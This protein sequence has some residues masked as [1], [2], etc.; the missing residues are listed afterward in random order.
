LPAEA[1]TSPAVYERE[2]ARIFGR[3]WLCA[4]R[5]DQIPERGD[6]FCLDLLDEKLVVV[7]GDD[8]EIRAL[9][10][11]CRHRAAE[12]A[13]GTGNART[14]VCPYHSWAYDLEGSLV[15]VPM[16]GRIG[17]FDREACRLPA[18]RC[19]L[20]EGWIFVNFDPV[21]AALAPQ[22]EPLSKLLAPYSMAS[23]AVAETTSYPS[24]FNWK[25]LVDN[26]MEAYHHIATHRDTLQPL[27]PAALSWVPDNDGPWSALVM[28]FRPEAGAGAP[29][30]PGA[31][32]PEGEPKPLVAAVVYPFHLF[33]PSGDSMAWYQILPERHD[34]FTLRIHTCFQRGGVGDEADAA[35]RAGMHEFTNAVHAQD[36]GACESVWTGLASP[37]FQSGRLSTL[38]KAIWQFNQW[39]AERMEVD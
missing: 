6:Y 20:W 32:I 12:V 8:G 31:G 9:S 22:L 4:G 7:R 23:C 19:E 38:E 3:E 39:W 29:D 35:A 34:R 1:F 18:I 30:P 11:I 25:V 21:A 5:V 15:A 24:A 26:F 13:Q 37:S 17:G 28:P 27:M 2:V 10:R 33:A 14:L 16:Q 36:I